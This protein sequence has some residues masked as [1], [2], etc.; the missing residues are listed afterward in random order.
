MKSQPAMSYWLEIVKF[1]TSVTILEIFANEMSMTV[2]L[3]FEMGQG[4]I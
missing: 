2:T 3:T 1:A 4:Q